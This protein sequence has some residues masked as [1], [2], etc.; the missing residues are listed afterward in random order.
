MRLGVVG[1]ALGGLYTKLVWYR[2][3]LPLETILQNTSVIGGL[4]GWGAAT[5]SGKAWRLESSGDCPGLSRLHGL[6]DGDSSRLVIVR[7]CALRFDCPL[8]CSAAT[9]IRCRLRCPGVSRCLVLPVFV[10]WCTGILHCR[11]VVCVA[12]DQDCVRLSYDV[13]VPPGE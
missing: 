3:E 7:C 13:R 4:V 11:D 8:L 5:P 10:R 1:F 6:G 12:F 2:L 9:A